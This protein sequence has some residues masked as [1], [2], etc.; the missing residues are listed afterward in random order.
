MLTV[1]NTA[2]GCKSS[3]SLKID[4]K[5]V[6]DA[7]VIGPDTNGFC[8]GGSIILTSTNGASY[9]WSTGATT[10]SITVSIAGWLCR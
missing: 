4:V 6:P 10:Q 2:T 8:M 5:P 9:I 3:D 1:I 7:D